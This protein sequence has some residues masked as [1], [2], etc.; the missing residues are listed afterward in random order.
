M[1]LSSLQKGLVGHWTMSQ[2]SLKGS[3]LAD[4]TP[5]ENDGTIYGATFTT[6]RKGKANSA[7]YFD[8]VD[9]YIDCGNEEIL[10]SSANMTFSFW[11]KTDVLGTRFIL[12]KRLNALTKNQYCILIFQNRLSFDFGN[13]TDYR[14]QTDFIPTIDTWYHIVFT[15]SSSNRNLYID[16]AYYGSIS[17]AGEILSSNG[18][19]IIGATD[20]YRIDKY[21]FNGSIDDVRIYNYALTS[22]QIKQIYN[23]GAVNFQ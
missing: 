22:E 9:D 7:M 2:D 12:S 19:V 21:N 23:G 18:N 13:Y 1:K 20:D 17:V 14:W 10:N 11:F 16:G 5:Y 8:G 15:R 4:K 3:L 6:D